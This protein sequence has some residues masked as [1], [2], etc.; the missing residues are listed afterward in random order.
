MHR[1]I[2]GLNNRHLSADDDRHRHIRYELL[3]DGRLAPA[4]LSSSWLPLVSRS[5]FPGCD[6]TPRHHPTRFSSRKAPPY[7]SDR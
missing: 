7:N 5:W 6:A 1:Q 4:V 2:T 3:I